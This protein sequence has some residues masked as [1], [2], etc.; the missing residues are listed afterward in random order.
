M[1]KV[2]GLTPE[3]DKY[4]FGAG[5]GRALSIKKNLMGGGVPLENNLN[6]SHHT[7]MKVFTLG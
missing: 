1:L 2:L 4:P 5:S 7:L 3:E 6:E